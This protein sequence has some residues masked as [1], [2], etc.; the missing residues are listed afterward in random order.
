MFFWGESIDNQLNFELSANHD[1]LIDLNKIYTPIYLRAVMQI[2][3]GPV[4]DCFFTT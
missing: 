2:F 4:Y 1:A 3:I